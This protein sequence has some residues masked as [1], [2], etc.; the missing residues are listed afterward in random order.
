MFLIAS[1]SRYRRFE[2]KSRSSRF[3]SERCAIGFIGGLVPI[4]AISICYEQEANQGMR[5]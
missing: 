3:A 1:D 4:L 2:K 5:D